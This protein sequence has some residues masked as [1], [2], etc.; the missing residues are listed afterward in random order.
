MRSRQQPSQPETFADN[1]NTIE[2]SIFSSNPRQDNFP[3]PPSGLT[4]LGLPTTSRRLP[5]P[6]NHISRS[7]SPTRSRIPVPVDRKDES[8]FSNDARR[9]E[10]DELATS[11]THRRNSS[12]AA[13]RSSR[14]AIG[15]GISGEDPPRFD[16]SNDN[17]SRL[18]PKRRPSTVLDASQ[19]PPLPQL[20]PRPNIRRAPSSYKASDENLERHIDKLLKRLPTRI[21]FKRDIAGS[22]QPDLSSKPITDVGFSQE[23]HIPSL[24]LAPAYQQEQRASNLNSNSGIRIFELLQPGRQDPIRLYVRLVG[25]R[26]ER[27]V[28]RVGGGWADLGEVHP[29]LLHHTTRS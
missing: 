23:S 10:S 2:K 4:S 1:R 26:G 8:I 17:P 15:L 29:S 9:I 25:E 12:S 20:P 24:I 22:P 16:S 18:I 21:H 7:P 13:S 11:P 6:T 3:K 27:V 19:A 28:V 5:Q 14:S